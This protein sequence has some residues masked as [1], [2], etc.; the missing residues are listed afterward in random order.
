MEQSS[1]ESLKDLIKSS[2]AAGEAVKEELHL[3][4]ELSTEAGKENL[5]RQDEMWATTNQF[6]EA[7]ERNVAGC[8]ERI[9][10]VEGRVDTIDDGLKSL[11]K[12]VEQLRNRTTSPFVGAQYFFGK[13]NLKLETS[14][15]SLHRK[16]SQVTY[17]SV[18]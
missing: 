2:I 3:K 15:Q 7:M 17:Q 5:E 1:F 18:Q 12:D 4:I 14:T 13:S 10:L 6:I 11:K 16:I 9:K 8:A